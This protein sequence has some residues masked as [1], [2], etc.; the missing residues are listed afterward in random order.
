MDGG[1]CFLFTYI[2]YCTSLS[3]LLFVHRAAEVCSKEDRKVVTPEDLMI[4][5]SNLGFDNY[6]IPLQIFAEKYRQVINQQ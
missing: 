5:L 1:D 4:A 6:S 2:Q 3:T